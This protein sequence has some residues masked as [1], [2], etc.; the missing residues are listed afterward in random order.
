MGV[1]CCV[2][3]GGVYCVEGGLRETVSDVV[4]QHP[5]KWEGGGYP[6]EEEQGACSGVEVPI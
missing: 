4:V 1:A 6:D 2:G 5:R 3:A